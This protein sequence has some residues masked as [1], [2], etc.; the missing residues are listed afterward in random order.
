MSPEKNFIL[1]QK[2]KGQ[3]HDV[4]IGFRTGRS[5]AAAATYVSYVGFS[6]L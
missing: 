3:G 1:G 2:V 6:M 5:I 4:C